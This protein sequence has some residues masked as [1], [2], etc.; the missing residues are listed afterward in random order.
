MTSN[1]ASHVRVV[2][3]MQ[4]RITL[5]GFP[6]QGCGSNTVLAVTTRVPSGLNAALTTR[7]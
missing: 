6:A 2:D 4:G 5:R 7:A 3:R 1:V